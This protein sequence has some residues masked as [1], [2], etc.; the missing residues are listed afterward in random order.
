MGWKWKA[1]PSES[2]ETMTQ[3]GEVQNPVAEAQE[4]EEDQAV[5]EEIIA[6]VVAG[7]LPIVAEG[8]VAEVAREEGEKFIIKN[9]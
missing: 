5:A 8:A 6:E 2:T 1:E 4:A 9:T 7:H 3:E